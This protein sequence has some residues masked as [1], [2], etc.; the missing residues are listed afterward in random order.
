MSLRYAYI[1]TSMP[2]VTLSML[3]V[4]LNDLFNCILTAINLKAT[5]NLIITLCEQL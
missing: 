1:F 4:N 3:D 5:R 2:T